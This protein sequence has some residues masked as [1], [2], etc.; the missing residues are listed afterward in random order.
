MEGFKS[1]KE[2]S[3]M[4]GLS[5]SAVRKLKLFKDNSVRFRW[6]IWIPDHIAEEI[7]R[8]KKNANA[9]IKWLDRGNS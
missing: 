2:V 8:Q 1:V 9:P 6:K 4:S 3:A 5:G 7:V